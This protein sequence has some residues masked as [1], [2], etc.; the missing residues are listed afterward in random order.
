MWKVLNDSNK[1]AVMEIKLHVFCE[2][3]F[4]LHVHILCVLLSVIVVVLL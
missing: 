2:N 1:L 3:F 4:G